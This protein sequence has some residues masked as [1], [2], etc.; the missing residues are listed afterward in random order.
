MERGFEEDTLTEGKAALA[1]L[2]AQLKDKSYFDNNDNLSMGSKQRST[3]RRLLDQSNRDV[4][5]QNRKVSSIGSLGELDD[6]GLLQGGGI[7]SYYSSSSQQRSRRPLEMKK[8]SNRLLER[9][10]EVST[11]I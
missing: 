5:L 6:R 4:R 7:P 9:G 2:D 1:L 11:K 8:R 3:E 10:R